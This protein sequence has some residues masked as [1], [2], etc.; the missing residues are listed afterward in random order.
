MLT[1]SLAQADG[2]LPSG[3]QTLSATVNGTTTTCSFTLPLATSGGAGPVACP[4]GLQ[5]A[6]QATESCTSTNNGQGSTLRCTP[7]AGQFHELLTFMGAPGMVHVTQTSGGA[8]LVDQT[9]TPSY[10]KTY[11]NGPDCD[12]GCS[13]AS[14]SL[15]LATM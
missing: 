3:P 13:Q 7:I 14:V 4:G 12:P 11:P 2:T 8:T 15:V 9:V 5:L 1:V 6:I 10:K